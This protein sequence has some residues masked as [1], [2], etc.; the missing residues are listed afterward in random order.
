MIRQN[1]SAVQRKAVCGHVTLPLQKQVSMTVSGPCWPMGESFL[2]RCYHTQAMLGE[3]PRISL[4]R[5]SVPQG[6]AV[7][8]QSEVSTF[9]N[10]CVLNPAVAT[11]GTK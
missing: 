3:E 7:G 4:S 5:G 9:G 1:D 11:V 6:F 10:L 2:K 8:R